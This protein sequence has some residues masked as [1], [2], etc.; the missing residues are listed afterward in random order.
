M[1][2]VRFKD[3]PRG[4]CF[5]LRIRSNPGKKLSFE[6]VRWHGDRSA[7]YVLSKS[8]NRKVLTR[9]RF[10]IPTECPSGRD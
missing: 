5:K 3:L 2:K 9:T 10:V 8:K 6:A 7:R 1:A 4:A